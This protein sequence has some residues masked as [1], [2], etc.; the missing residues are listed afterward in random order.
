MLSIF[1]PP[2]H[3]LIS[4]REPIG[5]RYYNDKVRNYGADQNFP[6]DEH[7]RGKLY[8]DAMLS[9]SIHLLLDRAKNELHPLSTQT[10]LPL[11]E[12]EIGATA[13]PSDTLKQRRER[14]YRLRRLNINGRISTIH[15]ALK[16]F[17]GDDLS[18][19]RTTRVGEL[20]TFDKGPQNRTNYLHVGRNTPIRMLRLTVPVVRLGVSLRVPTE[21]LGG[22]PEPYTVGQVVLVDPGRN[23]RG[24]RVTIEDI[25]ATGL[26][27]TFQQPHDAQ[28]VVTSGHNPRYRTTKRMHHIVLK[29]G[30]ATDPYKVATVHELMRRLVKG[31]AVWQVLEETA[32]AT[33]GPFEAGVSPPGITSIG[34]VTS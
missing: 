32:T 31:T 22:D 23:S 3:R 16:D 33:A 34:V 12:Q 25:D 21:F 5:K 13:L 18:F 15:A 2:G 27:A 9:A 14:V 19:Y 17:L 26:T 4:G 30:A 11:H 6:D 10:F 28:T 8:A 1:A 24:E 20:R 7:L 29:N